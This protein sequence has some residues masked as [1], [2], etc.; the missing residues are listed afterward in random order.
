VGHVAGDHG[1]FEF[2]Q[3]SYRVCARLSGQ[4]LMPLRFWR[5]TIFESS[6]NDPSFSATA[7]SACDHRSKAMFCYR[8]EPT[9]TVKCA[10]GRAIYSTSFEGHYGKLKGISGLSP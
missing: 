7:Y 3:S 5:L 10:S 6:M 9:E 8:A 1:A 4:N 2:R